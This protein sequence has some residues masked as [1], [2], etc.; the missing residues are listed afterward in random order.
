MLDKYL[1]YFQHDVL[2]NI[3]VIVTLLPLILI[4]H[5]KAYVDPSFRLLLA[6]LVFRFIIDLIMYHY[7]VMRMNNLLFSNTTI[8]LRYALLSGMFYYKF[9][10]KLLKKFILPSV[11]AFTCFTI[12]DIWICNP[13][14]TNLNEHRIVK[15]SM[16][17]ES[18]LMTFWA[19]MYFY[20]LIRSLRIPSLLTFPFFWI[21]SGILI[22]YSSLVFI[23]PALHY[24]IRWEEILHIGFLDRILYIFDIVIIL[25]FSMGI[26]F[27]SARY[28]ARQ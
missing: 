19:L 12:W 26:W 25:L 7:A 11:I 9:E 27:F 15:Y 28:Y 18:L 5:R 20:E 23:S 2:A 24:A 16:T 13:V 14:L 22:Y 6:F 21:C 1:V 3:T 17:L 10:N 8:I 4:L